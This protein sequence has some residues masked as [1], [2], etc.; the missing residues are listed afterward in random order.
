MPVDYVGLY[1]QNPYVRV[2]T[3]TNAGD[4]NEEDIENDSSIGLK[5]AAQYVEILNLGPGTLSI[6]FSNDGTT[7]TDTISCVKDEFRGYEIYVKKVR[8]SADA[9]NTQYEIFAY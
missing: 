8:I 5:R 7:F 1:N 6:S 4:T 9:D 2:G 3:V